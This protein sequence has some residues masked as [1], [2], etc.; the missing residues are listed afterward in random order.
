[1]VVVEETKLKIGRKYRW[2]KKS[3]LNQYT[4]HVL[5]IIDLPGIDDVLVP[6]YL[7]RRWMKHRQDWYYYFEPVWL[8]DD[9]TLRPDYPVKDLGKTFCLGR[10]NE[11]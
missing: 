6:H 4:F 3:K 9:W 1:M 7:L 10:K 2:V 8:I 5:D 11:S